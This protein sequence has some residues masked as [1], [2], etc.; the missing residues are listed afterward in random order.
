[1][2][3]RCR[4]FGGKDDPNVYG[5]GRSFYHVFCG[6]AVLDGNRW[7]TWPVVLLLHLVGAVRYTWSWFFEGTA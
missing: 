3:A 4:A 1:M 7:V 2:I 5:L 6:W